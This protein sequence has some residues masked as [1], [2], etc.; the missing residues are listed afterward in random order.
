MK[1]LLTEILKNKDKSVFSAV[2]IMAAVIGIS[3]YLVNTDRF[4][5]HLPNSIEKEYFDTFV[6]K[7]TLNESDE[8]IILKGYILDSSGQ[9]YK[10][11]KNNDREIKKQL[12]VALANTG[13]FERLTSREIETL[14]KM[15]INGYLGQFFRFSKVGIS[16][17][18]V[19]PA[20]I[21]YTATY[22][23]RKKHELAM[24]FSYFLSAILISVGGYDNFRYQL[25][26]LPIALIIVFSALYEILDKLNYGDILI[27]YLAIL[28]LL[29]I[30]YDI[31]TAES[32][33]NLIV[34]E[35]K[36]SYKVGN[37]LNLHEIR[38]AGKNDIP[39]DILNTLLY[40]EGLNL[41]VNE[42]VLVNNIL[43]PYYYSNGAYVYYWSYKDIYHSE[44]GFSRLLSDNSFHEISNIIKD[45]LGCGYVLNKHSY[46]SYNLLFVKYLQEMT[47]VVFESGD[48]VLYKIKD[49]I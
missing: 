3:T 48:Y 16:V 40:I 18:L 43:I 35:M 36:I 10:L 29:T 37:R 22:K 44:F 28:L 2:L 49:V 45:E 12:I 27:K 25:S 20:L 14:P 8:A 23:K 5:Y 41:P 19:F 6:L 26:L 15:V 13:F 33:S 46:E 17:W 11:I 31:N 47:E 21:Y 32:Y 24:I 7:K 38:P 39:E 4:A 42:C 9:N 30:A 1:K 34:D